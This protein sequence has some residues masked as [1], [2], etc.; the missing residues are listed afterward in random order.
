[1]TI[2]PLVLTWLVVGWVPAVPWL[3][4]PSI[5]PLE[6]LLS[7]FCTLSK[8]HFGYLHWVSAFLRWSISLLSSSGLLHTVLAL[9]VRVLVTLNFAER[10][11]WLSHCKY[12]SKWIGFLYTVKGGTVLAPWELVLIAWESLFPAWEVALTTWELLPVWGGILFAPRGSVLTPWESALSTW[13]LPAW[14]LVLPMTALEA[15]I[16][17][18]WLASHQGTATCL[19]EGENTVSIQGFNTDCLGTSAVCLGTTFLGIS[20]TYDCFESADY[21]PI[22]ITWLAGCLGTATCLGENTVSI[23]G[24]STDSLGTTCFGISTTYDCIGSADYLPLLLPDW[25]PAWELLL[26]WGR[27]LL[28]SRDSVLTAWEVPALVLVLPMTALEVLTTCLLLLPDWLPAWELLPAWGRTLLASRD[29]ALT[30]W[31]LPA[32]GLVLPMT[33]NCYLPGGEHC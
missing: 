30:A 6:G 11:W 7:H 13:E 2:W 10:W 26:A 12:W 24:F 3:F 28:A 14:G 29:S 21:L 5:T 16:I 33:G 23:Q 22:I 17:I 4:P 27:T 19:G 8:A 18:T 1:M 32:L 9:W 31:E 20:T 25:L 15:P